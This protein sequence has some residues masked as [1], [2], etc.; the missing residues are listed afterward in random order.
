MNRYGVIIII[1]VSVIGVVQFVNPELLNLNDSG[2]STGKRP[3]SPQ[4]TI[5]DYR[6][7]ARRQ[8]IER[9]RQAA[10]TDAMHDRQREQNRIRNQEERIRRSRS[11]SGSSIEFCY[12]LYN[13]DQQK[14]SE[15]IHI[16]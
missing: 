11:D 4:K 2:A 9:G 15:C 12:E 10:E 16:T 13:N 3:A 1:I 7:E 6:E 5:D 8:A 14:L